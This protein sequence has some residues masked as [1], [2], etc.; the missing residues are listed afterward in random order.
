MVPS[1]EVSG[2]MQGKGPPPYAAA[3]T[4]TYRSKL[5]DRSSPA[6]NGPMLRS[7]RSGHKRTV[8]RNHRATK[9]LA[10]GWWQMMAL[11]VCSGWNW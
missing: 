7:R 9:Y 11:V 4:C 6:P 10:R 2:G 8:T 1:F 5:S 3:Q